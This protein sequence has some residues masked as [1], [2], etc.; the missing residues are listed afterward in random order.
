[1]ETPE[2]VICTY[3]VQRGR[4][5]E[6]E[7]LLARHWPTLRK[8]ELV[9]E[10]RPQHFRGRED[11]GEPVFVEIF[12]WR[13]GEAAGL[14]HQFPEVMAIWEPMDKLTEPRGG[15]PNMEFPHFQPMDVLGKA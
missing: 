8:L 13:N 3:R 2:I 11:S 1:M 15:R 9:G 12:A 7:K 6:F 5:A 14:A 10:Q 4:E